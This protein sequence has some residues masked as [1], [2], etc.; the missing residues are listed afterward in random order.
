MLSKLTG[1]IDQIVFTKG[2]HYFCSL[3][4]SWRKCWGIPL[5]TLILLIISLPRYDAFMY[6]SSYLIL[7]SFRRVQMMRV[8]TMLGA[9]RRKSPTGSIRRTLQRHPSVWSN[10]MTVVFRMTS[11][12]AYC[13]LSNFR[14][15]ILSTLYPPRQRLNFWRILLQ[16]SSQDSNCGT[17]YFWGL[18]FDLPLSQRIW[19][20]RWCGT[21]LS[22]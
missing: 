16:C 11:Q 15:T 6:L 12:V 5:S 9:Q 18:L 8:V 7:H 17:R 13:A 2:T 3:F 22:S 4:H 20:S 10:A 14:G 19:K 21:W 1:R